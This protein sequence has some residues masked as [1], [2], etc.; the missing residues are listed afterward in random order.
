MFHVGSGKFLRR[1]HKSDGVHPLKI[2]PSH[3]KKHGFERERVWF[4][5]D[6]SDASSVDIDYFFYTQYTLLHDPCENLP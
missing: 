4:E 3:R 2:E 1:F 5:Q 6:A